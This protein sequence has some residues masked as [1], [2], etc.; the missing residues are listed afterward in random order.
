MQAIF[1]WVKG[2]VFYL[3][4]VTVVSNL[5]PGKKYEKYIRLFTGMLL[6]LV[7]ARPAIQLIAKGSPLK[8]GSILEFFEGEA[9]EGSNMQMDGLETVQEE[10]LLTEYEKQVGQY[11]KAQAQQMGMQSKRVQVSVQKKGQEIVPVSI[12]MEV[13]VQEEEQKEEKKTIDIPQIT[14]GDREEKGEA[15]IKKA[16]LQEALSQYYGIKK[17]QI[18]IYVS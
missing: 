15:D 11:A 9:L 14:I 10:K 5:I 18:E 13:S 4:F 2:I 12:V 3:I 8:E 7:V 16:A 17:E 6:I 1:D